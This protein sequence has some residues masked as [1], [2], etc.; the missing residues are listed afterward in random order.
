MEETTRIRDVKAAVMK[1]LKNVQHGER[2]TGYWGLVVPF[3][4]C[5]PALIN[6]PINTDS[7][8]YVA[9]LIGF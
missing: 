1:G 6:R 2:G 5:R 4:L 3:V 8:P 9:F 7:P